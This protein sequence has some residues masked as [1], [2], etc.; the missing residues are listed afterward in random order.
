LVKTPRQEPILPA[1]NQASASSTERLIVP[2]AFC[3]S[4]QGQGMDR[5]MLPNIDQHAD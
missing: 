4:R 5:S 3:S 1:I 2:I